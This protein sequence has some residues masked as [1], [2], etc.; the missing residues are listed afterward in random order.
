VSIPS[1]ILKDHK[2]R[3]MLGFSRVFYPSSH[4]IDTE[5]FLGK[6][7]RPSVSDAADSESNAP[8]AES[9]QPAFAFSGVSIPEILSGVC[10][11]P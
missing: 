7:C 6:Q 1:R 10:L 5:N 3:W 2:Y 11:T 9:K 4:F 8:P